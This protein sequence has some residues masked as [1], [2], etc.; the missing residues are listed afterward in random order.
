LKQPYPYRTIFVLIAYFVLLRL[1]VLR[2]QTYSDPGFTTETVTTVETF[3]PV[4]LAFAS[5][6]RI[7]IWEKDGFVRIYKNGAVLPTPFINISSKVNIAQD[8]GLLGLAL[9]PNFAT[10]G[11]VYLLYTFENQHTP[12]STGARTSRLTRVTA[13]PNNPDV[14]LAG[15]E[16]V[17]LGKVGTPPCP[18]NGN[19]CIPDDSISHT[20]GTLRFAPDGNLF[21]GNGDGS[22]FNFADQLALRAQDLNSYSGKILRIHRDGTAPLDNPFYDGTNSIRSKV[23]AYGLRNPYRFNLDPVTGEPMIGDVGWNNWEEINRGRGANFGWPCF[24][25]NSPEPSYAV[26]PQCQQ[27]FPSSVTFPLYTYDHT[28]GV[29]VIG[30]SYYTG[31]VYPPA[32]QGNFFFADY[33]EGWIKRA[34]FDANGNLS[35]VKT[36]ATDA[37]SIVSL[38]QAPDGLFYF[39][40]F[41]AGAIRRIRFNGPQ[42]KSDAVPVFGYSPLEV[43]FSSANSFD[44]GGSPLTYLW[45]FDD[46]GQTSTQPNP[47]HSFTSSAVK[48]F[49]V[50]LTVTNLGAQSSSDSVKIVVGST[51]PTA[52]ILSPAAGAVAKAGAF[53]DFDGSAT[54]P[55]DG[56]LPASSLKWTV[57]LH[58]DD[59]IH[60]YQTSTGSEGSFMVN[61]SYGEGTFSFEII[62]TAT[63]SSGLSDKKSI[64]L[65]FKPLLFNDDFMDGDITDWRVIKDAWTDSGNQLTGSSNKKAQILA[66][67]IWSQ[68]GLSECSEC[69]FETDLQ[70][71]SD[72]TE[73]SLLEWY[74]DKKNYVEIKFMRDKNK[75]L[76]KQKANGKTAAHQAVPFQIQTGVTYHLKTTFSNNAFQIYIDD[77]LVL[78]IPTSSAPLGTLGFKVQSTTKDV[79]TG[80]FAN[81]QIY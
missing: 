66:P 72:D 32:Y 31:N 44:P 51:P 28:N 57:L 36:F 43:T 79:A 24:E 9:D 54:D 11:F 15:S 7:F 55:D 47:Q 77:A 33:G 14:A 49:N 16:I 12:T 6:G 63:D 8:R 40:D 71:Q 27:M 35:E 2:A 20:I 74:Q 64:V 68:S 4:G 46:N 13:D 30:G 39:V 21:V 45:D 76:L 80:S 18:N 41:A 70:S 1:P 59:H 48:T 78:D 5:D 53:V 22:H 67:A 69:T 73:L 3:K 38:E 26:F 56:P 52:T 37:P 42:A 29:A 25:G 23:W 58:H 65:P 34:V 19:D 75:L 81:V 50:K 61:E 60:S 10:N 17:L 62:L